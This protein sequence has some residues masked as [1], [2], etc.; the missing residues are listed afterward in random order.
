MP[1]PTVRVEIGLTR[2]MIFAVAIFSN[3]SII[4]FMGRFS[5]SGFGSQYKVFM[6]LFWPVFAEQ[7]LSVAIGLI[8]TAMVAGAGGSAVAGVGL[9]GSV[10]FLVVQ[11]FMAVSAGA[12]VVVSHC[13]GRG[14]RE[15]ARKTAGQSLALVFY[16]SV[17]VGAVMIIF[18]R[19]ILNALF[20][21]AE[22]EVLESA[23][24]YL[25]YSSLSL[26]LFGF[27]STI[28]GAL[29]AAGDVK[30]PMRAS[31]AAIITNVTVAAAAIFVFDMGVAGAG[32]GVLAY[33]LA[34]IVVL[35]LHIRGGNSIL[36]GIRLSPMVSLKFLRPVLS[37][38]APAG[39]DS[40]IFNGCKLLVQTFMA[41]MGTDVLT[42][43]AILLNLTSLVNMPAGALS[44]LA[45]SVVGQTFGAGDVR[46][47]CREARQLQIMGSVFTVFIGIAMLIFLNPIIGIFKVNETVRGL[48]YICTVIF[49]ILAPLFWPPSFLTPNALRSMGMARYTMYVSVGSMILLRVFGAW[50][51]GVF[52]GFGLYGIW[53]SMFLDWFGRGAFFM[54]ALVK[55]GRG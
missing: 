11:A 50:F 54:G 28:N 31:L 2:G 30:T 34:P 16:I 29:R 18:D 9:V 37:V 27:Y 55:K 51:L 33:R 39:V 4:S 1:R 42:A 26:P 15:S 14:D 40:V 36:S 25:L 41:G 3:R 53:T 8:S 38:A 43:Y 13:I 52:W 6:P 17:I 48:I 10:N 20:G 7:V 32:L 23:R 12:A 45:V 35:T 24:I 46:R 49:I 21:D 5:L 47:A 22:P 44:V 19:S